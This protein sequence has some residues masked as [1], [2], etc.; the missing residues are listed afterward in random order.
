MNFSPTE[1]NWAGPLALA[2]RVAGLFSFSSEAEQVAAGRVEN[3]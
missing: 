1:L 2:G 3:N